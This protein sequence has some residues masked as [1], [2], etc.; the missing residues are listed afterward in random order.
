MISLIKINPW[1]SVVL[2]CQRTMY[3]TSAPLGWPHRAQRP[4]VACLSRLHTLRTLLVETPVRCL[5]PKRSLSVFM[6]LYF[7]SSAEAV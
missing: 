7:H 5:T 2:P 1:F 6:S 4:A 3:T